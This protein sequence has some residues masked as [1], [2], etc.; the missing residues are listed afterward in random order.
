MTYV[1]ENTLSWDSCFK[2]LQD[3][4]NFWNNASYR[5]Y[6]KHVMSGTDYDTSELNH[7]SASLAKW[8]FEQ[9]P[10]TMHEVLRLRRPAE[11]ITPALF[12]H[13]QDKTTI[14][15]VC[16]AVQD[17]TWWQFMESSC[18]YVWDPCEESRRWGMVCTCEE[19]VRMLTLDK[20]KHVPCFH[21][22]KRLKEAWAHVVETQQRARELRRTIRRADVGDN[23]EVL[24][25]IK[26][27]LARLLVGAKTRFGYLGDLPMTIVNADTVAGAAEVMRQV[28]SRPFEDLDYFTQR[29]VRMIG[30]DIDARA[31][32]GE[33]SPALLEVVARLCSSPLAEDCGEGWEGFNP[34]FL[35]NS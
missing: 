29:V 5:T 26:T 1:A 12:D 17:T 15:S 6:V 33:A 14:L 19:H 4:V 23:G 30:G 2:K 22:S 27:M 13:A 9:I 18:K 25:A 24:L 21:N 16:T 10:A 8:R 31:A 34:K 11:H 28:R 7:F 3:V 35:R 20:T 32:G